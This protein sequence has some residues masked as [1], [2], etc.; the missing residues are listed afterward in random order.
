MYALTEWTATYG[1]FLLATLSA[2]IAEVTLNVTLA[3]F[4]P[5]QCPRG[6]RFDNAESVAV[7]VTTANAA[8]TGDGVAFRPTIYDSCSDEEDFYHLFHV[9]G[10]SKESGPMVVVGPGNHVLCEAAAR[11]LSLHNL[12]LVSWGCTDSALSD[13]DTYRTFARTST[14]ADAAVRAMV[15]TLRHFRLHYVTIVFSRHLPE[16]AI[17]TELH[18]QLS[19][20][21]FAI[22]TFHKLVVDNFSDTLMD[23]LRKVNVEG[24]TKGEFDNVTIHDVTTAT[25][26]FRI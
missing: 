23:K 14:S 11:L 25:T 17:A 4:V 1:Y 13:R 16:S 18:I 12:P 19:D 8:A 3:V 26:L 24:L 5:L 22:T 2:A 10:S 9:L 6:S 20:D 7:A 15:L 21:G